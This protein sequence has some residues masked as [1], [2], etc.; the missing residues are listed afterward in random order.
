V[1]GL[2]TKKLESN[3]KQL[4]HDANYRGHVSVSFPVNLGHADV[5]S[6]TKMN[7]WRNNKWLRFLSYITFMFIFIWPYLFF[8]TK[9]YEVVETIWPFSVIEEDTQVRYYAT[10]SEDVWFATWKEA[11]SE[12]ILDRQKRMLQLDDLQRSDAPPA[13]IQSGNNNVDTAV[14][15]IAA[16]IRG[17]R[18][19]SRALPWGYDC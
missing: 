13:R 15:F 12:A 16:G 6:D 8:S 10:V 2:D 9:R 4:V 5:Y 7:H 1:V 18:E 17:A 19:V 14:N 11:I 3:L